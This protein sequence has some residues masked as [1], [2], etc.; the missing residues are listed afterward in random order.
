MQFL[1][2]SSFPSVQTRFLF[3]PYTNLIK[4]NQLEAIFLKYVLLA[5]LS[6]L[7]KYLG[8]YSASLTLPRD[9]ILPGHT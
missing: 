8:L 1:S 6:R 2:R 5:L 9:D 4:L 3:A 7:M